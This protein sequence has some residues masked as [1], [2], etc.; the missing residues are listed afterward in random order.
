MKKNK[1]KI[2]NSILLILLAIFLAIFII[3]GLLK[4]TNKIYKLLF[5]I[6]NCSL[7]TYCILETINQFTNKKRVLKKIS[8]SFF[9]FSLF[10]IY[11][12]LY[13]T[14]INNLI[15]L[16]ILII[17]ILLTI[18]T[19][20]FNSINFKKTSSILLLSNALLSLLYLPIIL[21]K[22]NFYPFYI[23]L[24]GYILINIGLIIM[25]LIKNKIKNLYFLICFILGII[26]IN[27]YILKF[28]I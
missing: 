26:T 17:A 25:Y 20:I 11:N 16:I 21:F 3:I 27:Y 12:F 18:L 6:E 13:F 14:L 7:I 24:I 1:L 10:S 2:V 8:K 5:I 9:A 22:T 4:E 15:G 23:L 19:I 28:V